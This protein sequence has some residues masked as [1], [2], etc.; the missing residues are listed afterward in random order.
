MAAKFWGAIAYKGVKALLR[1]IFDRMG[2]SS[3]TEKILNIVEAIGVE[4]F[5]R[6]LQALNISVEADEVKDF[7]GNM[8]DAEAEDLF[9]VLSQ[10]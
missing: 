8:T 2:T 9:N 1:E 6:G 4:T 7:V 3:N 10:S 5:A